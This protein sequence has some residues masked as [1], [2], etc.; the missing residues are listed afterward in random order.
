MLSEAERG[1]RMDILAVCASNC[2]LTRHFISS[3]PV[4]CTKTPKEFSRR[5]TMHCGHYI[6]SQFLLYIVWFVS[7]SPVP[8][9]PSRFWVGRQLSFFPYRIF[10]LYPCGPISQPDLCEHFEWMSCERFPCHTYYS[11]FLHVGAP[12]SQQTYLI[13]CPSPHTSLNS[14]RLAMV[15]V[16]EPCHRLAHRPNPF[17]V[18]Q[19]QHFMQ[20]FHPL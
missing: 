20:H 19:L 8:F 2:P 15:M 10:P 11:A 13:L 3:C 6:I 18:H 17:L 7:D 9:C 16:T 14:S 4:R 5:D 1:R 12:K